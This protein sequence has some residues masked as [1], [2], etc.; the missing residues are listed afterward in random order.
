MKGWSPFYAWKISKMVENRKGERRG[1]G[2]KPHVQSSKEIRVGK[3]W[4]ISRMYTSPWKVILV[5][6]TPF[7]TRDFSKEENNSFL[8]ELDG[9]TV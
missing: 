3:G 8:G 6:E 4:G 1:K 9:S 5:F 2:E 7:G